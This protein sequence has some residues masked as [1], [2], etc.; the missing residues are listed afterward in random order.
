MAEPLDMLIL[1]STLIRAAPEQVYQ[2]LATAE[3]L[4]AWFTR[5]ATMDPRP[6]GSITFRWRDWGPERISDEGG[7][8]VLEAIPGQRFVFQWHPDT[9]AYATTV[10][11]DLEP[12][13]QGTTVRLRE[14]GY[15]DTPSGREA[16]TNCATGWGEALTLLKFYLEHSLRY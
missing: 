15:Q 14:S 8:A 11:I 6:G 5:G 1:H 12:D 7:G 3:G 16:F 2:A 9:E 13:P 10:E 4:D